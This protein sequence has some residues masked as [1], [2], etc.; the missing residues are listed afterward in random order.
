MVRAKA[1]IPVGR[2]EMDAAWVD[3]LVWLYDTDRKVMDMFLGYRISYN[4]VLGDVE[5]VENT[6]KSVLEHA[7]AMVRFFTMISILCMLH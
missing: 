2:A 4:H 3:L 1:I 5:D 7:V 6:M